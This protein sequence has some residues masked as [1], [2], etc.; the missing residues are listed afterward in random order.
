MAIPFFMDRHSVPG[1]TA[2]DVAQAHISDLTVA[3]D[4]GVKFVSYWFDEDEGSVFC[5]ARAPDEDAMNR[6]H[7]RSHGLIPAEI[8][9]VS[10]DDVISFLG[11]I[12]EPSDASEI[13]NPFRIIVFTDL[14]DSTRLLN[15]MG[16]TDFLG[17]LGQHDEILRYAL[18]KHGGEEVKHTGDGIMASFAD[19]PLALQWSLD[20]Q[21]TFG[22]RTDMSIRVGLAGGE[23]V[24]QHRDL[25]GSAVNLA[26][27]IC[28]A[29]VAGQVLV[30]DLVHDLGVEK[31]FEFG[32]AVPT[33]LKGF[34]EQQTIYELRGALTV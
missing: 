19:C 18:T 27:R 14:V 23:P 16:Q 4:F 24:A 28:D 12:R 2:E 3:P 29:A 9:G 15:D 31:R 20:V 30:S 32:D 17:M 21:S 7:E 10:E 8:I 33:E 13:T 11:S 25:F 34:P 22:Q 1:I 6:V 26:N 5:F